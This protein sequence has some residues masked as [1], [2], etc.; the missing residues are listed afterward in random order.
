MQWIPKFHVAGKYE[1][2]VKNNIATVLLIVHLQIIP[3]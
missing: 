3:T 1:S 2:G